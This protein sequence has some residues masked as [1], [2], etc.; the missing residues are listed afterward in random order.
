MYSSEGCNQEGVRLYL[1]FFVSGYGHSQYRTTTHSIAQSLMEGSGRGHG[2]TE[3]RLKKKTI[4]I[5]KRINSRMPMKS[6]SYSRNPIILSIDKTETNAPA[7][8]VLAIYFFLFVFYRLS[9]RLWCEFIILL[10]SLL[11]FI[12][13]YISIIPNKLCIHIVLSPMYFAFLFIRCKW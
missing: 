8:F 9:Y 10:L 3:T 11:L 4:I 6:H 7:L 5:K 12:P 1:F 2:W 13:V